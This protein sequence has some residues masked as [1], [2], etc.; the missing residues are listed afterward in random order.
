MLFV[1][2]SLLFTFTLTLLFLVGFGIKIAEAACDPPECGQGA[3]IPDCSDSWG[4]EYICIAKYCV[5]RNDGG[6]G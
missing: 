1:K 6:D 3:L 2:K 4:P 5:I